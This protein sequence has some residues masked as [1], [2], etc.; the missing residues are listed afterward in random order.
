[1]WQG[2]FAKEPFDLKLFVLRC[3]DN[4]KWIL[5]GALAGALCIGGAYY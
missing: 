3:I 2:K 1:M 4:I 5:F